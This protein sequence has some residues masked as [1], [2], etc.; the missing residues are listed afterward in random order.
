MKRHRTLLATM[1][2]LLSAAVA[3]PAAF[4]DPPSHAPAHGWR[5]KHDPYYVGYTGRHWSDD[6]GIRAG[7]CDRDHVATVIGAVAGGA[8]GA[9]VSN[10]DNRLVAIML[11]AA[12]GAVVGREIDRDMDRSDRACFGHAL[13]LLADDRRVRWDGARSGMHYALTPGS[14]FERNGKVCRPFTLVRDFGGRQIRK[15]GSACRTG[16]GDWQMI[17][18]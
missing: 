5:K 18:S 1:S 11:G 8:I 9:A 7:R 12:L 15:N 4:A 6:Y 13:E 3:V 10:D 14:R 17:K 16:D 2:L